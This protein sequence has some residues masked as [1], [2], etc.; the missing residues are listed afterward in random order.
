MAAQ[1]DSLSGYLAAAQPLQEPG[2]ADPGSN[3]ERSTDSPPAA[4]EEDGQS[5][6]HCNDPD[7][8]EERFRVDRKKLEAMLQ[9]AAEGKGKSGEDF[10]QKIMEE[11][12]TQIAWPSKLKIG[13]K[14]KKDPHIKVGG[15]KENV[16]EAKEKIMSVLDTKSNRV[17]LKMDVSHTEHSHVIG[18]GGNNIKKVME[19]TGCHIHF[20]DSNRNNQTEKSNQVSIAGQASGVEAAR[21]RIRELLPLVMMF[22]LPIA[23]ILQPIPDPNSPTIQHLS[24]TYNV[25][26]SFK[27]RSRMYGATV[28]VR[29]SQN[30]T[31]AVKEGTAMLLEHLAGSLGSAIP[32]STQLDIAPQHHLFMMGRNG[33][34]IKHIMQR[35]GAQ[36]HF[37]DPSNP[38]KKSTVYLQGSIESVCLARQYLMG[39]LPLV[40]MFDMKEDIEVEPQRITQLMEQLDVFISIK[41]KPKQPSK[42]VIVKSVER[43]AVNMYEAR[44]C[45]LG[46]E[47]NGVAMT[48]NTPLPVTC[49][50][51]LSCHGLDILASAGLGLAGLGF[52][53]VSPLMIP[54]TTQATLTSILLS[55]LHGYGQ[56]PPS[57]PPGLAP[58][59]IQISTLSPESDKTAT[60]CINGHVKPS[61]GIYTRIST[62]CLADKVLSSNHSEVSRESTI[63]PQEQLSSKSSPAE[64]S[65]DAFVEV[66]M[67]RSPSHSANSNE[68]K[69]MLNSSSTSVAK[70]QT[71]EL[72]QG[73]KNTHRHTADRLL[74]DSDSSATE[75]TATDKRAP[76]SERAAERAAA[77]QNSERLR[78]APQSAYANIQAFD[79]EQKKLLATKAMLKKPVVTE[80][81]TPTNTWS[82]LGFS[83]SMP[84][85]TIK[86]LRCANHVAYKPS[87]STTYE[88]SS[89]VSLSR[90]NSR[91]C[92]GGSSDSDNWRERNGSHG[93]FPTS[94]N[95]VK[96]KNNPSEH[97]LTSSNYMD[98]ISSLMGSNGCTLNNSFKGSELPELF[99][100]LGLGKYTDIFQ[101]Q[102]IDLQTFLTLTDPDL[103]E[104]GITTFGARRKMLLAIS[105]LNKNCRK[106]FEPPN[107]RSTFLEG[108]ASGRLPRQYHSDITSISGRW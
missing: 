46:L 88:S 20:P 68:L 71:L 13:A 72:L 50:I 80:V 6:P 51:G 36:I 1:C 95:S 47:N 85:E 97:Y 102:E 17:T 69:Q 104:L 93:E 81:R 3:S 38:Q 64:G 42:S 82:G 78:L 74:S 33:N 35:A 39:C 67:P 31:A 54:P 53:T 108:G 25:S 5:L 9:A 12:N 4:S 92:I 105:E 76:G 100:K 8:L 99:S 106:S 58:M 2:A 34:N 98:C 19:E 84:A 49:P 63:S 16:K 66:G 23:G 87:M 29:G 28:I 48:T 79:Y 101:Q 73:T 89:P 11:T 86:E 77:Q 18:K 7:W 45:L 52:S 32:I 65:N 41:P 26:I 75:G 21:G 62:P 60:S 107:I 55:G 43:N 70:R 83:K 91:E 24:Q 59:D 56:T 10:F 103:K 44:K 22:D 27:Q 61:S 15:K 14:S 96:Q 94:I 57:P 30:N 90:S 40:L 37:P